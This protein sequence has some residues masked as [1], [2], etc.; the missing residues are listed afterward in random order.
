M[1]PRRPADALTLPL[2]PADLFVLLVLDEDDL[3]GYGIMKAVVKLSD[4]GVRV[5]IGSLYR[6]VARMT[7]AGLVEALPDAASDRANGDER[8]RYYRIT[9]VG[10]R[11]LKAEL[12]RLESVVAMASARGLLSGRSKSR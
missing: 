6:V 5:D 3:H 8:R 1:P 12:A 4:G 9:T 7:D 11:T 10:R 2:R